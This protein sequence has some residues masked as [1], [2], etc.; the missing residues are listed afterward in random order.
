MG[1]YSTVPTQV[2]VISIETT[3]PQLIRAIEGGKINYYRDAFPGLNN[4][5]I[6]CHAEF[7]VKSKWVCLAKHTMLG[8]HTQNDT[9]M[10][11]QCIKVSNLSVNVRLC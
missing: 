2:L 10:D 8:Y 7:G 1:Y 9:H 5:L 11:Q 4:H 6:G 3:I